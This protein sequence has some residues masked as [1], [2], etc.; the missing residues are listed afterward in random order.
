MK[1]LNVEDKKP[2]VY[3]QRKNLKALIRLEDHLP[4][5]LYKLAKELELS[6]MDETKDE[7][8]VSITDKKLIKLIMSTDWIIDYRDIRDL[9]DEDIKSKITEL[10]IKVQDMGT[11]YNSL[12]YQEQRQNSF[13]PEQYAKLNQKLKDLNA[14]I[15]TRQGT[16]ATPIEIPLAI[17]SQAGI[18][19][20]NGELKFGRSLDHQKILIAKKDGSKFLGGHNI[21]PMEI[22]MGLMVFMA[23]ENLTPN[24]PGQMD[25]NIKAEP[26]NRFLVVDYTFQIDKDYVSPAKEEPKTPTRIKQSQK[27]KA[28]FPNKKDEN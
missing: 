16:Y 18:V 22:N 6:D 12:S 1:I 11:Y 4:R 9:S 27:V 7:E 14:Y 2:I 3:V 17:D 19:S 28:I 15:W 24:T 21:N 8:F 5:R 10:T 13:L 25:I 23:E 20:S 26:T